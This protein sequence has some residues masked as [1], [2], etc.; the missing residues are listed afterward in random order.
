V[1]LTSL[2]ERSLATT[3]DTLITLFPIRNKDEPEWQKCHETMCDLTSQHFSTGSAEMA[4]YS[5]YLFN[6]QHNIGRTI[7]EQRAHLNVYAE[8]AIHMSSVIERLEHKNALLG[9]GTRE[10]TEKDLELSVA[11][12][13]LSKAEHWLNYARQ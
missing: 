1:A 10:S 12:H 9:C 11:Y 2:C 13:R 7:I 8:Q 3:A 4:K 5:R 6:L